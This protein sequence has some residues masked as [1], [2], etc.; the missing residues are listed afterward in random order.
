[1]AT[2]PPGRDPINPTQ[3]LPE[4]AMRGDGPTVQDLIARER[5]PVPAPLREASAVDL[6]SDPIAPERYTDPAFLQQEF[7]AL[8]SSVWQMGCREE[9]ISE[10]G[11]YE[12]YEIG[13]LSI[14]I[15]RQQDR[16]IRAFHNVCL[17][18]GRTLKEQPGNA[19]FLRCPFHGFSWHLDGSSRSVTNG[20]DFPHIDRD[21]FGLKPVAVGLWGGFV[22]VNPAPDPEPFEDFL[23]DLRQIYSTRGWDLGAR[24]KA[25][26]VEKINR[27]NW[28][29]VLEAFIES[30]HVVA[31]HP[32]AMTYLGDAFTQY[33]VWPDRRNHTRMISP[34]GLASPHVG[35]PMTEQDVFDAGSAAF[36]LP[37]EE[38]QIPEGLS[39]R[40]YMGDI[41]RRYLKDTLGVDVPDMTDTEALDTIQYHI[42]PNLV[43]WAG[44]GSFLVYRFRP[45]G[46]D[47]NSSIMEVFFLVPQ[48]PDGS[49]KRAAAPT[50]LG[51]DA[52]HH[53]A[54][55]LGPFA[56][57][58][59]EDLSNIPQ[60]HRGLQA[61]A[62][63]P[64]GPIPGISLGRYQEMR[65]RHFHKRIDDYL[66]G[67]GPNP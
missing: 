63:A 7:A 31:T 24:V 45:D 4:P 66:A 25:V 65:I 52:S 23:E 11:D 10:P 5:G 6:G 55:E 40:Q 46:T 30:F 2:T 64:G 32:S 8:W 29:V 34:R 15:V 48:K 35:R 28:K 61:M 17:H 39:A 3:T 1:M 54:P 57:V 38:Q 36:G 9:D 50:Q 43:C 44:W 49:V 58:F 13:H 33:D 21:C 42:F 41:K 26:H 51:P 67:R 53:D 16:S 20:W 14:L 60:V 12:V 37:P 62:A 18:R 22:F 59:D 47:V 56:A 19:Q 27:C